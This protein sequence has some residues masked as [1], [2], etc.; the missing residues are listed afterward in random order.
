AESFKYGGAEAHRLGLSLDQ[1]LALFGMLGQAGLKG[2]LGGTTG[3]NF[4]R[5]LTKA[6]GQFRTKRQSEGLAMM[7]IRPEDIM[8]TKGNLLSLEVVLTRLRASIQGMNTIKRQNVMEAVFGV[9]GSR[10][11]AV[12]N[13]LNN[14]NFGAGFKE[15]LSYLNNSK[16]YAA[17]QMQ[18]RMDTYKKR[19]DQ[20]NAATFK[21]KEALS[22]TF[23]PILIPII[24]R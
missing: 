15:L 5:Y 17:L 1:T 6:V 4:L 10:A 16:G 9:R 13:M 22:S 11:E 3:G 12:L 21:F 2:S 23:V 7:G 8:D 14:A 18:V 24:N 19:M 20:L